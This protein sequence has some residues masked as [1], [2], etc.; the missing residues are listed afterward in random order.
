MGLPQPQLQVAET[1]FQ[2]R[3]RWGLHSWAQGLSSCRM[4][5]WARGQMLRHGESGLARPSLSYRLQNPGPGPGLNDGLEKITISLSLSF[6]FCIVGG[7]CQ[8]QQDTVGVTPG[9]PMEEN[10]VGPELLPAR[11]RGRL[12]P[13]LA[14]LRAPPTP[15]PRIPVPQLT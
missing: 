13:G 7:A 8:V 4:R 12:Q 11:V 2:G 9:P 15:H 10:R 1:H 6:Q 14:Q 5:A 3:D